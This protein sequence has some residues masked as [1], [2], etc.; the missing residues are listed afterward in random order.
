MRIL[1][2]HN[3]YRF[4][5]GEDRYVEALKKLLE[6]KGHRVR[7]FSKDSR[8]LQSPTDKMKAAVGLVRGNAASYDLDLCIREFKP[9]IAQFQNIFPLISYGA[10]DI[11]EKHAVPVVLRLSNYRFLCPKS[12][13]F[14]DGNICE[15]CVG[16]RFAYP[17]IMHACYHQSRTASAALSVAL[18]LMKKGNTL[19]NVNTFLFPTRFIRDYYRLHGGIPERKTAVLNTFSEE[20]RITARVR[21]YYAY[22]GRLAEEKGIIPL[23]E[24]FSRLP[25]VRLQVAGDGPL[26]VGKYRQSRNIVFM[27]HLSAAQTHAFLSGARATIIPSRSYDVFPQA[28]IESYRAGTPVIAPR[29]GSF[30]ELVDDGSTGRMYDGLEGLE[31]T[32]LDTVKHRRLLAHWGKTARRV[33]ETRFHPLSHYQ[34][35]MDIYRRAL[36][37]TRRLSA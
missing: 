19:L 1:I 26:D 14:R 15:D 9:D 3:F 29:I 36:S 30:P 12:T 23:L 25:D 4:R 18:H 8:S 17:N 35:L 32:V 11:C 37:Q 24:L 2:V 31:Q 6:D 28:L 27:G 20:M 21:S 7:L 16:K 10:L 33:Y 13:L 22:V 5:G 34:G